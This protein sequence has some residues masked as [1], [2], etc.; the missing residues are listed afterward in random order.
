MAKVLCTLPNASTEI[1]GI[2]FVSHK[3]GMISEEIDDPKVVKDLLTIPGF[4]L[5][6]PKTGGAAGGSADESSKEGERQTG[7][8]TGA[9]SIEA[10]PEGLADA[11][12]GLSVDAR[13]KLITL[14]QAQQPPATTTTAPKGGSGAGSRAAATAT[15]PS[16]P[17]PA[18]PAAQTASG[19]PSSS[20][21]GSS[22]PKPDDT[23]TP[24]F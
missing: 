12:K 1:N 16:S 5:H 4:H 3:L 8:P 15:Q 6:D 9:G 17:P 2:K 21:G 20:T 24:K 13:Q 18:A 7:R 10:T 14:L 11:A 22:A 23:P 19:A